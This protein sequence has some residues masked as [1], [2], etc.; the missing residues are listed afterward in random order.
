MTISPPA[1]VKNHPVEEFVVMASGIDSL[2]LAIDVNWGMVPSLFLYLE[3]LKAKAKES[4][5]ECRGSIRTADD[6]S[7]WHFTIPPY[8]AKG[9]EWILN[10]KDFTFKI[11]TWLE[12]KSMPSILVE[13]RSETLWHLGAKESVEFIIDLLIAKGGKHIT[14]K[15]SRVDMCV[16]L[17]GPRDFWGAHLVDFAVTRAKYSATH[18][19]NRRLTGISIG[20]GVMTAR[21]YDKPLEIRQQSKKFWMYD[22]WG[23]SEVPE[24]QIIVRVEFQLRRE[25]IVA[26]GLRSADELFEFHANAWKYCSEKWLKFQSN[27]GKHHTQ[28]KT[29]SWWNV[30]QEG[31]R[32]AQGV[33][34]LV[35]CRAIAQQKDQ[36]KNQLIGAWSSLLALDNNENDNGIDSAKAF[37]NSVFEIFKYKK[38][39]EENGRNFTEIIQKKMAKNSR[40]ISKQSKALLERQKNGFPTGN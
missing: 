22:I 35:R 18:F 31:F 28:R 39:L 20:R 3:D 15:P 29:F 36:F 5:E 23:I 40:L 7:E 8:G 2:N 14:V 19:D 38:A 24:G 33:T 16:D 37:G 10:G 17:L 6:L 21:L 1:K 30:I 32:G 25:S 9:Y 26:L 4:G 12:P 34:P 27:P 11:G 13:I